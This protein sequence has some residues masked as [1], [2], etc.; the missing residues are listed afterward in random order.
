MYRML[1]A[2]ACLLAAPLALAQVYK[3]TDAA[4]TVHFSQSPPPQGTRY[5]TMPVPG[6][7]A[8]G[9]DEPAPAPAAA[10]AP[11]PAGKAGVADT[12]DNRSKLCSDL[13]GNISL[14]QSGQPLTVDDDQGNRTA[15]DDARR[16]QELANAQDQ[17]RQ[18]CPQ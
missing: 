9:G 3:W 16:Q 1:V 18:F 15:M 7:Q 4:G 13:A 11:A 17:Y 8:P 5:Q 12:P 6:G 14:L 10:P 2:V